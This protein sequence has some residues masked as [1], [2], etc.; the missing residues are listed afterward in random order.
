MKKILIASCLLTITFTLSA[1]D[2]G[3]LVKKLREKF[4]KVNDYT[5][6]ATLKTD[7]AFLQIPE[8]PVTVYYKK[9]DKFRIKRANGI[10]V[11]PKGGVSVNLNS[12]LTRDDLLAFFIGEASY[13]NKQVKIVRMMSSKE[14]S[15]LSSATLYVDEKATLVYK[16]SISTKD[17]GTYEMDLTYGKYADWSLPDKVIFVFNTKEYK[18]PKGITVDFGD[19]KKNAAKPAA[20]NKGKVE[21]AYHSYTINKGIDDAVF[22]EK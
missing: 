9:P 2:A 22:A 4:M 11:L 21:I 14:E 18:M 1:Q 20:D 17:N 5:A 12:L 6:A 7:V 10:S 19:D 15:S 16:A 3:V 13:N 8:T